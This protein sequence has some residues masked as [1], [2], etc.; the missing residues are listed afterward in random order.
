MQS[1]TGGGDEPA[2]GADLG[3]VGG[4]VVGVDGGQLLAADAPHDERRLVG[5]RHDEAAGAGEPQ[6]DHVGVVPLR[7]AH[8]RLDVSGRPVVP[9]VDLVDLGGV[10]R[11]AVHHVRLA[12]GAPPDHGPVVVGDVAADR[13]VL[14]LREVLA[15]PYQDTGMGTETFIS[16]LFLQK[17]DLVRSY[18]QSIL[19]SSMTIDKELHSC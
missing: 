18:L 9:A 17:I 6:A 11:G 14:L 5:A 13:L 2:A 16:I 7:E 15:G 10:L 19:N 12:V 8:H 4:H 1:L 3:A